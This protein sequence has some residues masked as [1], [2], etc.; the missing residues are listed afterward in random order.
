[1]SLDGFILVVLPSMLRNV[2]DELHSTTERCP[3]MRIVEL[4]LLPNHRDIDVAREHEP[5]VRMRMKLAK[6]LPQSQSVDGIIRIL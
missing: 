6:P 2:M 5:V 1:M 4:Q 3:T